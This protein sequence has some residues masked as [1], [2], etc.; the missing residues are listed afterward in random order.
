MN[1]VTSVG[2]DDTVHSGRAMVRIGPGLNPDPSGYGLFKR[3]RVGA[4]VSILRRLVKIMLKL[5]G[6]KAVWLRVLGI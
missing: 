4:V 6:I 2:E 5:N 3:R 1:S